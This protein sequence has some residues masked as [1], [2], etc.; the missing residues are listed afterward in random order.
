MTATGTGYINTVNMISDRRFKTDI[1]PIPN[2]LQ[3]LLQ[4]NG[5]EFDYDTEKP[6]AKNLDTK[7]H[8]GVIA[9]ELREIFPDLVYSNFDSESKTEHLSV[10]YTS[11]LPVIIEGLKE[12]YEKCIDCDMDVLQQIDE[13]NAMK[14]ELEERAEKMRR[15]KE[16]QDKSYDKYRALLDATNALQQEVLM[17]VDA[18]LYEDLQKVFDDDYFIDI[19]GIIDVNETWSAIDDPNEA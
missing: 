3:R 15:F 9:Q 10:E 13:L 8:I 17:L 14:K 11:L 19:S 12:L 16:E 6:G 4:V 2:A 7:R 5:V 1:K 18:I